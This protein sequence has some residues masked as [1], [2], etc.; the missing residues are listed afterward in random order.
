MH[1]FCYGDPR[2][3]RIKNLAPD[4][5]SVSV[6]HISEVLYRLQNDLYC[7]GWGVKLY[8]NQKK[9]FIY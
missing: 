9:S 3:L 5:Y 2:S 8:S 6:K 7:V 4:Q 1:W